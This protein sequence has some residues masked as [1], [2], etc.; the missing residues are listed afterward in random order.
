MVVCGGV[1]VSAAAACYL[2]HMFRASCELLRFGGLL[3][4]KVPC[5]IYILVSSTFTPQ[6][7]KATERAPAPPRL[8]GHKLLKR[9]PLERWVF[10][11]YLN[12]LYAQFC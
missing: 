7:R 8:A 9:G 12:I 2:F 5:L 6:A 4:R 11:L 1:L 3:W 10:L